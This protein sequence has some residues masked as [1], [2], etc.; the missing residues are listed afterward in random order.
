MSDAEYFGKIKARELPQKPDDVSM[1]EWKLVLEKAETERYLNR[2]SSYVVRDI[3]EDESL[4]MLF[5]RG[6]LLKA[7]ELEAKKKAKQESKEV[8]ELAVQTQERLQRHQI[9]KP[10]VDKVVYTRERFED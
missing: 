5:R 7:S 4:S 6:E 9:P 1:V 8:F 10:T 2:G 3:T